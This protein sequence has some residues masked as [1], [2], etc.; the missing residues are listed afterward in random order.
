MF[1]ACSSGPQAVPS[2][3]NNGIVTRSSALRPSAAGF[4]SGARDAAR[5]FVANDASSGDSVEIYRQRGKDQSPIGVITDGI[6]TVWGL[7]VDKKRT[8]YAC[9]LDSETVTEYPDDQVIHSKTLNT[10]PYRPQ[11]VKVG[12]DGTVYVSARPY[13]KTGTA[14]VLEFANG[15]TTPTT[16]LSVPNPENYVE[17]VAVDTANN[18][19]VAFNADQNDLEVLKFA[20]GRHRGVNL[21]IDVKGGA[22][23][24]VGIDNQGNPLLGDQN[25]S[26]IHVFSRKTRSWRQ[27]N[28]INVSGD[29]VAFAL[30]QR[31]T[32]IYVA[33]VAQHVFEFTYP[34]GV[35]IDRITSGLYA[36]AGVATNPDVTL[37]PMLLL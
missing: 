21:G 18:L 32:H 1:T 23:A 2:I 11:Y 6:Y 31:N 8:L 10:Y 15:S 24:D 28:V 30:N 34:S 4:S 35:L 9:N 29:P 14:T 27:S 25:S 26:S 16:E 13:Y 12:P 33:E 22:S 37:N 7:F 17:G 36:N 20:P 19:Y 5:V 3:A